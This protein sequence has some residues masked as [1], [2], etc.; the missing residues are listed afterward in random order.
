M[1]LLNVFF[2]GVYFSRH[3]VH[4]I[5]KKAV[6]EELWYD[7]I[8]NRRVKVMDDLRAHRTQHTPTHLKSVVR[9]LE[10]F[11]NEI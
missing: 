5:R 10:K 4:L 8:D 7:Q 3:A 2:F 6:S 9:Q 1:L 11:M